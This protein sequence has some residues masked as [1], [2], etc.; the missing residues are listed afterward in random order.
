VSG[1]ADCTALL[2]DL[3]ALL[4]ED[5]VA[6]EL[7]ADRLEALWA[8]LRGDDAGKAH[9]ALTALRG[10][11]AQAL[12]RARA[13]AKPDRGVAPE[14]VRLLVAELDSKVF[15]VRQR[16]TDLLESFDQL[17]EDDL[18]TAL[19]A[20]PPLEVCKRLERLLERMGTGATMPTEQLEA[21][22]TLELLESLGTPEARQA[23]EAIARGVPRARLT[24][25]AK[26]VEQRLAR[27]LA[28]TP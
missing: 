18:R 20:Q 15:L 8:D 24:R 6:E 9:R 17:V 27:R 26:A 16:A 22:R 11:P 23:V 5:Q 12:A 2:F 14:R 19:A 25:E 7:D 1:S 3:A 21:L 13:C 10:A 4:P 28:S